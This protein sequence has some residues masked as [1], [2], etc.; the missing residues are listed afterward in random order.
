MDDLTLALATGFGLGLAPWMPGTWGSLPAA[1]LGVYLQRI[2]LQIQLLVAGCLVVLAVPVCGAA[3]QLLQAGD[4][5]RI[6]ADEFAA[7][8][9]AVIGFPAA[10]KPWVLL[11]AFVGYRF[12]DIVKPPPIEQLESLSGGVGIVF[13][14]V[15][16]ALA[17]RLVLTAAMVISRHYRA[18]VR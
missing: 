11:A 10:R 1:A 2:S 9:V 4:A 13:D 8:P 3:S 16:A 5:S 14:D 15:A 18:A 12:F 7:F 6:V 17:T